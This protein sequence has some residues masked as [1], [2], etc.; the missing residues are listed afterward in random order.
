M[1]HEV[2][3]L[4]ENVKALTASLAPIRKIPKEA[5]RKLIVLGDEDKEEQKQ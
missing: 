2:K 3:A 1:K 4:K 5:L